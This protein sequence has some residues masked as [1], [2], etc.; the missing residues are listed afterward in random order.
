V[1]PNVSDAA[2]EPSTVDRL[3]LRG[4]HG[5]L[6]RFL[7]VYKFAIDE[8]TTKVNILREEFAH[9]HD[10]NPI[11]H[12]TARLKSPESILAKVRRRDAEPTL[13]GIR[14][15]IQDIA[16][17]RVTCSFVADVHTIFGMFSDQTDVTVVEIE[18]YIT[19]PKPNGYQS[20][21]AIVE[22]PVFLSAGPQY[23][24]VE[25]QFRT[26]AMDFWASLEHKIYYKYD[27]EIPDALV[28][29]LRDAADTAARL[30]A[31]MQHLHRAV[32][33]DDTPIGR[34]SGPAGQDVTGADRRAET[35]ASSTPASDS[36]ASTSADLEITA[37]VDQPLSVNPSRP[38]VRESV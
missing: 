4:G 30:D 17:V 18:D 16:G 32:H 29:E 20:L 10:Y 27:R 21:H 7:M 1:E 12:V 11:E 5:E 13:D 35:A 25:M 23:V 24:P 34:P 38:D 8:V 14:A 19:E 6:T 9:L 33:G 2:P 15:S 26:V 28:E 37:S 22:V 3:D 36:T 31:R